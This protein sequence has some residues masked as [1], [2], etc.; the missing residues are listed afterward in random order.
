M[1]ALGYSPSGMNVW[2]V[3]YTNEDDKS[4]HAYHCNVKRRTRKE[5]YSLGDAVTDDLINWEECLI[6][7]TPN[8]DG[9]LDDLQPWTGCTVKIGGKYHLYYT[10]RE[11]KTNARVQRIGLALSEDMYNFERYENN[12]VITTDSRYYIAFDENSS[13]NKVDCRDLTLIK[14]PDSEYWYCFYASTCFEGVEEAECAC[15]ACVRSRR[16]TV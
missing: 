9:T 10:I 7:L 14:D 5:A 3:W 8:D 11:K 13:D 15:V 2:D 12:P 4:V 1:K 6:V 16:Y